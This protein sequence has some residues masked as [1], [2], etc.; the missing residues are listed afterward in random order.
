MKRETLFGFPLQLMTDSQ[1]TSMFLMNRRKGCK[2]KEME[3]LTD[4]KSSSPFW[5]EFRRGRKEKKIK[6]K[7]ICK[8]KAMSAEGRMH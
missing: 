1:S 8:M 3:S 5:Q 4:N 6:R 7:K 2:R